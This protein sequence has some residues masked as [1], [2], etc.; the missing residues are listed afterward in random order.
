MI[1]RIFAEQD[2]NSRKP[3]GLK[4]FFLQIIVFLS[5]F[6]CYGK[7]FVTTNIFIFLFVFFPIGLI[8]QVL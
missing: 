5:A 8:F 3:Y 2:N 7:S 1:I 6:L 4:R